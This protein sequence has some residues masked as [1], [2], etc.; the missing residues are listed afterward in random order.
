M[1]VAS[2]AWRKSEVP[3]SP[4]IQAVL[5]S[6][7]WTRAAGRFGLAEPRCTEPAI[8]VTVAVDG[9]VETPMSLLTETMQAITAP[10][11]TNRPT[12]ATPLTR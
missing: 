11:P 5:E 9:R 10:V 7:A 2:S 3:G 8:V 4:E 1:C 6:P 12:T